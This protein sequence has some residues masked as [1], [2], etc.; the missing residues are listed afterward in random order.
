MTTEQQLCDAYQR[1]VDARRSDARANCVPADALLDLVR[2]DGSEAKRLATLD[3]AMACAWCREEFEL[4]RSIERTGGVGIVEAVDRLRWRRYASIAAA[5]SVVLAVA[6]GPGRR[7]ISRDAPVMRGRD[8]RIETVAPGAG[9]TV[10]DRTAH[11][12]WR[13]V[14]GAH[15]YVLELLDS[16]GMVAMTR[17]TADTTIIVTLDP[18]IPAGDY[19]WWVRAATATGAALRSEARTLRVRP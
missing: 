13:A 11:F 16:G 10:S 12:A 6:I 18:A 1:A 7:L 8:A 3:H 5:A 19:T 9:A 14:P 15:R 4:L 17:E 2:R